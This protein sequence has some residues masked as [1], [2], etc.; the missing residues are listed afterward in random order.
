M[1][2]PFM[3][4]GLFPVM[5]TGPETTNGAKTADYISLK[6]AEMCWVVVYMT[7]AVGHATA[8]TIDRATDVAATGTVAIGN[9][10]PIWY[11]NMTTTSSQLTAQTDAVSYTLVGAVTGDVIIVFQIDP[12]N[13]GSTYDCITA[14]AANSGQ[15][16]NF[17]SVL[18]FIK[19]RYQ[20][21]VASM[22]ATEFLV[23]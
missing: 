4:E 10:V 7:Q 1:P 14:K 6:N 5:A 17:W 12:A 16:T 19:P 3:P 22:T 13:L 21:K 23:D 2:I 9:A 15:A 18:Y 20:S 11:G 8:I